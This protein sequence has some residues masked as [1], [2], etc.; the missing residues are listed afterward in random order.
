[1]CGQQSAGLGQSMSAQIK[2][3]S[4]NVYWSSVDDNDIG[5]DDSCQSNRSRSRA[6]PTQSPLLLCFQLRTT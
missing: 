5:H 6:L 2:S 4:V 1:V 3:T